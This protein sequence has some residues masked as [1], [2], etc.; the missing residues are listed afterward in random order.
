MRHKTFVQEVFN[1]LP[2]LAERTEIKLSNDWAFIEV[3]TQLHE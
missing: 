1:N 3:Q 2:I